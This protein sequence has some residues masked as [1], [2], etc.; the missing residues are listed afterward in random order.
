MIHYATFLSKR[1]LHRKSNIWMM[2]AT[3]VIVIIFLV[4]NIRSQG[5]V[6]DAFVSEINLESQMDMDNIESYSP[7][8]EKLLEYYD[9]ENWPMFYTEY[10][11]ILQGH[12][13]VVENTIA[14]SGEEGASLDRGLASFIDRQL[15]HITYLKE[16]NLV[17]ENLNFPIFGVSFTTSISQWILPVMITLYCIYILTQVFAIDY[18]KGADIS[19]LFP[20]GKWK[21]FLTKMIVGIGFAILIYISILTFTFLAATLL[22][23]N[24]GLSYPIMIQDVTGSWMAI[25]AATFWKEWFV[26]GLFF[27]ISLSV[28]MYILSIFIR[29]E[30]HLVFIALCIVLGVSFLPTIVDY[31]K[32]VSHLIPTTYMNYVNVV[33]GSLIHQYYNMNISAITGIKVLSI[34]TALQTMFCMIYVHFRSS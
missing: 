11:A 29:E 18:V 2:L 26:I 7:S 25:K 21:V 5:E 28:F 10:D 14:I 4:M 9:E 20:I 27:Y 24:T 19:C 31:V 32:E 22:S 30:G 8:Y 16:H 15:K 13:Q 12:K 17:Y 23:G 34:F 6:R 33:N 1:I 3:M